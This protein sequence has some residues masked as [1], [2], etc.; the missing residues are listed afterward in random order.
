MIKPCELTAA[1]A[2]D[3]IRRRELSCEEL[4]RSCL[5]RIQERDALIRAWSYVD[6]ELA[7][8]MARELDKTPPTGVLHGLPVS[9]KDVID[10]VDMPTSQNSP[11]YFG[12]MAAKDAACAAVVRHSGGLILGKTDTVEFAA[13]GRKALTRNPH[14]VEHT[15]G[16]S[17]SGSAAAVS[18]LHV[19][20]S[21][22]TQTGGSLIRPA[23]FNGIYALK[24]THGVVSTEGVKQY[25]PTLDTVGWYGRCVADLELVARA[26]RVPG[27]GRSPTAHGPYRIGVCRTPMWER[28]DEAGRLALT[29]A[30]E[31]A[32]GAGHEILNVDLPAWFER[33]Y[34]AAEAIRR[35]EAG[36]VY[37]PEYLR[38][39]SGL[40]EELR[41]CV[42]GVSDTRPEAMV[43]AYDI[44]ASA[45]A[46]F[47]QL[48]QQ[49]QLHA[50]LTLAAP[51]EAPEGLHTT[52]DWVFNALWTLLHVPCVAVPV[53]LGPQHLP[54]GI[55]L[56]G[57]RYSDADLLHVAKEIATALD[58]RGPMRGSKPQ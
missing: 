52:G 37:L 44:A 55:Q 13:G 20:L 43:E 24:P 35:W 51:G 38:F 40:H 29:V 36:C 17:S 41:E 11:L 6:P 56:I 53:G 48:M 7:I 39:G 3:L 5:E 18:D 30:T 23:S 4:A 31:R 1:Q 25:A 27:I 10:T 8:R 57:A 33:L 9:F 50:V 19:P 58:V 15:P 21:F 47:D 12:H 22:G 26:L 42:E 32:K 2:V 46:A 45:R 49:L 14:D 16:G 54:V 34:G 28:A